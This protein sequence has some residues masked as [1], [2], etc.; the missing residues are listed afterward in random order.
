MFEKQKG[1]NMFRRD[2]K[3]IK[4]TQ[5]ECLRM[6]ITIFEIKNTFYGMNGRLKTSEKTLVNLKTAVE[7]IHNERQRVKDV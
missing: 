2:T 1:F 6:K 5:V 3:D 4:K 7:T